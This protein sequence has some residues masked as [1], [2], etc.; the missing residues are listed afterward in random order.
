[1]KKIITRKRIIKYK[2]SCWCIYKTDEYT[3]RDKYEWMKGG[4][5]APRPPI[6]NWYFSDCPNCQKENFIFEYDL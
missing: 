1:M 2:C 6:T 4:R 3:Y 5:I